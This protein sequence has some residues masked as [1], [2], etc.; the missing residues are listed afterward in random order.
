[1][2]N[3]AQEM[4]GDSHIMCR[5]PGRLKRLVRRVLLPSPRP[6]PREVLEW[7]IGIY[8]GA[9][10]LQLAAP[11]DIVNPVLTRHDIT[12]VRPTFIADPFMLS[13][14]GT[15]YMFFEAMNP[16]TGKGEIGL[17]TSTDVSSWE[18]QGIVLSEPFHLS[19]PHVFVW[20]ESYYMIPESAQAGSVL[21]YRAA[22]F[23]EQ[24]TRVATLVELPY[25][26]DSSVFYTGDCWW[27][28]AE[29]GADLSFDTLRLYSSQALTGPWVEHPQSPIVSGD[30]HVA[31]PAGRVLTWGDRIIRFAQDCSPKYGLN[32]FAF[33]VTEL[34]SEVYS[35]RPLASGP[36]LTGTGVG[37]NGGGMHH[38]DAHILDDGQWIACVDGWRSVLVT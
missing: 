22:H 16:A 14:D 7:S 13:V 6:V 17:A 20:E 21:L 25:V 23:P 31:R 2:D 1:M 12:D 3:I 4:R 18:Y 29:T 10:P 24:W 37:W 33:E 34:T 26:V 8:V 38:I 5:I 35:E 19:Y 9:S 28:F 27:M 32:V 11:D 15:W 30:P 36:I